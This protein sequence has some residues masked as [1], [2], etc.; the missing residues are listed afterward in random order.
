MMLPLTWLSASV[1]LGR[2]VVAMAKGDEAATV[3]LIAVPVGP[4]K[5]VLRLLLLS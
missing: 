1:P 5:P 4:K 3:A 2:K